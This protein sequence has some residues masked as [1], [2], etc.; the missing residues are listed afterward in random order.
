MVIILRITPKENK[1]LILTSLIPSCHSSWL[2]AVTD[3]SLHLENQTKLQHS[4]SAPGTT[5]CTPNQSLTPKN[6]KAKVQVGANNTASVTA[7]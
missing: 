2:Q 3:N 7:N 1:S 5:G 4:S 6:E